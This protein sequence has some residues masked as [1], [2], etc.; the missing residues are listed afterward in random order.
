LIDGLVGRRLVDALEP[1]ITEDDDGKT[2]S[3]RSHFSNI[4]EPG[5]YDDWFAG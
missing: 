1:S 2:F 3:G 5:D 4:R